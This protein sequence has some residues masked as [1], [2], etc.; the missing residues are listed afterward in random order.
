MEIQQ[1]V[2]YFKRNLQRWIFSGALGMIWATSTLQTSV[3]SRGQKQHVTGRQ[4]SPVNFCPS[5]WILTTI[6]EQISENDG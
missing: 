3:S 5:F 2:F 6:Q 1:V 4:D